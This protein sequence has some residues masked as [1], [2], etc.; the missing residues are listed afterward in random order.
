MLYIVELM[1]VAGKLVMEKYDVS[2]PHG[3]L[4]EVDH[5]GLT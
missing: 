2:G 5:D 3:G 1:Y 4:P